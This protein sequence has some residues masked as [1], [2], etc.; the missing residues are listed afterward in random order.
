M[1]GAS[2]P[3]AAGFGAIVLLI[4]DVQSYLILFK[5]YILVYSF[6]QICG[7]DVLDGQVSDHVSLLLAKNV[8]LTG[9]NLRNYSCK[10]RTFSNILNSA[11]GQ[12]EDSRS[13]AELAGLSC[14]IP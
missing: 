2:A 3:P 5:L 11:N 8:P 12:S 1:I 6:K 14:D 10:T 7:A 13:K 4:E 9:R